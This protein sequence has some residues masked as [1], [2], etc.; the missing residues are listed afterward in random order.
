MK[1]NDEKEKFVPMGTKV[2]PD[3]AEVWN[4]ICDAKETDTYHLLQQFIYMMVRAASGQHALSPDIQK[5]MTLMEMDAGWQ[6]AFNAANPANKHISQ[7]VLIMEQDGHKGFGA[8]MVNK[9]FFGEATMTLN[10]AAI[11]ERILEVTQN[12]IYNR[13]RAMGAKLGCKNFV[14]VLLLMLDAQDL[15]MTEE[16]EREEM[17]GM[18]E[19]TENGKHYAYGK[20]T[21]SRQHRNI[22]TPSQ[23]QKIIFSDIDRETASNEAEEWEGSRRDA[24][25]G[26]ALPDDFRPHGVEW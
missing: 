9:P 20:K 1:D 26:G 3:I 21:K 4:A 5:L 17:P 10:S 15:L 18:G 8:V 23:Q 2:S 16:E 24:G 19:Y 14:D 22:D 6:R 25:D 7:T 13:L 11:L 12:G